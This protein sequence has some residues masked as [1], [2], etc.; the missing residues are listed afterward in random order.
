MEFRLYVPEQAAKVGPVHGK[1]CHCVCA[2]RRRHRVTVD[3]RRYDVNNA[4]R[5]DNISSA[6]SKGLGKEIVSRLCELRC[7][8]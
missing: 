6:V 2:A 4:L 7:K 8:E 1:H 5:I 3:D